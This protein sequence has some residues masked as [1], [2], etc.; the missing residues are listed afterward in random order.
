MEK[1]GEVSRVDDCVTSIF[2][3]HI[4]RNETNQDMLAVA[5]ILDAA[6]KRLT[7]KIP[8]AMEVFIISEN[9]GCYNN[10]ILPVFA[11]FIA[12][13]HG[14]CLR[15]YLHSETQRG[16]GLVDAHFEVSMRHVNRYVNEV[17][18]NIVT[19]GD[20]V[21][22]L[23]YRD[24]LANSSTEL[25][26]VVRWNASLSEWKAATTDGRLHTFGW[27]NE[28]LYEQIENMSSDGVHCFQ[29]QAFD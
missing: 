17:G 15:G 19:P 10:Q 20:L 1:D 26:D 22:A 25:I 6:L 18:C 13:T 16:K 27:I 23:G 3:D 21:A 11:T 12:S 8:A 24:G 5:S 9:A 14:L 29:V 2:L 4:V 28:F 7:V